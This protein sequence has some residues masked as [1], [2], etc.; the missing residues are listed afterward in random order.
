MSEEY[1]AG[2]GLRVTQVATRAGVGGNALTNLNATEHPNGSIAVVAQDNT[3]Y[4]LD[5]GSTV[6]ADGVAIIAAVGG[7]R[8][9]AQTSSEQI[10]YSVMAK[11]F[12]DTGQPNTGA[13][14]ADE[15]RG[16]PTV[17]SQY[18]LGFNVSSPLWTINVNT[19]V[20]TYAGPERSFIIYGSI[21]M[22]TGAGTQAFSF[23]HSDLPII[24]TTNDSDYEGAV[25]GGGRQRQH[26][27]VVHRIGHC[28]PSRHDPGSYP[29]LGRRHVDDHPPIPARCRSGPVK[30]QSRAR[31]S[32][33]F[34]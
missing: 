26:Q 33:T 8:W 17:P 30:S 23:S 7:G 10:L 9:I 16:L 31:V 5:K 19:G 2:V 21:T 11:L 29:Q 13:V 27:P 22:S 3:V 1:L 4:L 18:A 20:L 12:L 34:A 15:W 24:G 25:H 32:A 6:T 14:V 28:R